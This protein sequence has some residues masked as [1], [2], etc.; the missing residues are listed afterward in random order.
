MLV[1]IPA[2]APARRASR[3][4]PRCPLMAIA[5]ATQT[6]VGG[7]SVTDLQEDR[8]EQQRRAGDQSSVAGFRTSIRDARLRDASLA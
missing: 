7:L 4:L 1:R 6:A 3:E 2:S 8:A 5:I